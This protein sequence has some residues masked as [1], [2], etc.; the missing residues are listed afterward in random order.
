[1]K[2]IK[3]TYLINAPISKVWQ[4]FIDPKIIE[5]WGGGPAKMDDKEGSEFSL[6]GGDIYG[7]NTRVVK[8]KLLEQDW[9]GGK[10]DAPSKLSFGF[11]SKGDKTEVRMV[12]KDVPGNEAKDIDQG[13]KDYYLG[14]LKELLESPK[15]RFNLTKFLFLL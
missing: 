11:T 14:P 13:W 5:Q 2:S 6:W 12:H 4:A 9:Y 3:Q 15:V 10:W 8:E 7:T 1:M